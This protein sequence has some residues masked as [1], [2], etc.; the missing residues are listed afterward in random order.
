VFT[1]EE[2]EA[3][4]E[5]VAVALCTDS[6]IVSVTPFGSRTKGEADRHSDV[7][8]AAIVDD[9]LDPASVAADWIPR[10]DALLPVHHRFNEPVGQTRL[11]GFLLES[12]V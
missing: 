7:D 9:D 3:T 1:P 11:C 12:Y 6:R 5:T 8:L 4:A 10:L 2:R